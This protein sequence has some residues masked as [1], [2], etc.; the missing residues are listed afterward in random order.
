MSLNNS[1]TPI[2]F[3][4]GMRD[5]RLASRLPICSSSLCSAASFLL[6]ALFNLLLILGLPL[7]LGEALFWEVTFGE[8]WLSASFFRMLGPC[9]ERR[10]NEAWWWM[11]ESWNLPAFVFLWSLLFKARL[12][13]NPGADITNAMSTSYLTLSSSSESWP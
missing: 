1:S 6:L 10:L 12:Q 13:A 11:E 5:L 7:G 3:P 4:P 9:I 2:S 8:E